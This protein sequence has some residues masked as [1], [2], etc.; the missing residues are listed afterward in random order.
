MS[1]QNFNLEDLNVAFGENLND[2]PSLSTLLATTVSQANTDAQT[3]NTTINLGNNSR[4]RE[5]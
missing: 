3:G 4:L 2:A 5:E 1:G